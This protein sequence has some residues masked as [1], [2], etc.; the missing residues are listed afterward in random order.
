[1]LELDADNYELSLDESYFLHANRC[2]ALAYRAFY[3]LRERPFAIELVFRSLLFYLFL[4]SIDYVSS[5][6]KGS[7][8][9]IAAGSLLCL[10]VCRLALRRERRRIL[11]LGERGRGEITVT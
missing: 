8:Q 9:L 6:F 3:L 11:R 2:L 10:N 4:C 5:S 7:Y 1:M